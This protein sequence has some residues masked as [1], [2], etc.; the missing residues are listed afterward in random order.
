MK[1]KSIQYII[2]IKKTVLL[3]YIITTYIEIYYIVI[4]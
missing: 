4:I 3:K 2:D 1:L